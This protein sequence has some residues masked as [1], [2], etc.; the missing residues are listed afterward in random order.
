MNK[1]RAS[2]NKLVVTAPDYRS[3]SPVLLPKL[4]LTMPDT[5]P[6]NKMEANP[7]EGHELSLREAQK[8]RLEIQESIEGRVVDG[9]ATKELKRRSTGDSEVFEVESGK[10]QVHQ[11]AKSSPGDDV[12]RLNLIKGVERL[13]RGSDQVKPKPRPVGIHTQDSL[14]GIYDHLGP[15]L[16]K[17]SGIE[18]RQSD[19]LRNIKF[20]P[21][22]GGIDMEGYKGTSAP[23]G[24]TPLRSEQHP[25]CTIQVQGTAEGEVK[26]VAMVPLRNKKQAQVTYTTT[27]G[28]TYMCI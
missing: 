6:E 16:I 1:I 11:T 14:A 18:G 26:Q 17:H 3:L 23:L 22:I 28:K 25:T 5:H 8:Y 2:S 27:R 10:T 19:G 7:V 4:Q 21:G 24:N 20:R 9:R 15:D 12:I 13:D